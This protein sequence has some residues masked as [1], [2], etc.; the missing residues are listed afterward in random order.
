MDCSAATVFALA[1]RNP[2]EVVKQQVQLGLHASTAEGF[3][4]VWRLEG[5]RGFF[6]GLGTS[7]LRDVPFAAMQLSLWEWFKLKALGGSLL[8]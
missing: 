6:V 8:F 3:S 2:F 1:C 4:A 5:M 7:M